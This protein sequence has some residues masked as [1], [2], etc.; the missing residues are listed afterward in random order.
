MRTG[1]RQL[2]SSIP[3]KIAIRAVRT[4]SK[5]EPEE[6][7]PRERHIPLQHLS[8]DPILVIPDEYEAG[9]QGSS[10]SSS[11]GYRQRSATDASHISEQ[12]L[13]DLQDTTPR[14]SGD[15]DVFVR[16]TSSMD[17]WRPSSMTLSTAGKLAEAKHEERRQQS[18]DRAGRMGG[19]E[20]AKDADEY[21][22]SHGVSR[23]DMGRRRGESS[24]ALLGRPETDA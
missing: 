20:I 22:S 13:L 18:R 15:D 14:V 7:P 11:P 4:T 12:L 3:S 8:Q 21:A 1:N 6:R 24:A 9:L 5:E 23:P 2:L 19:R 17:M 10:T 16:G